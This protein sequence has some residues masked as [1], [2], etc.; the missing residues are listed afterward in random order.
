MRQPKQSVTAMHILL[1]E[2]RSAT[3]LGAELHCAS[4]VDRHKLFGLAGGKAWVD[5][6]RLRVLD[7]RAKVLGELVHASKLDRPLKTAAG[8][9]SYSAS[10]WKAG[11][12]IFMV[13]RPKLSQ[14]QGQHL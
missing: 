13:E 6:E 5:G 7:E 9:C 12:R 1:L 11:R 8:H 2:V 10:M 4:I 3:H 14:T